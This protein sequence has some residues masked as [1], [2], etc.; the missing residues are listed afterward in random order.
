MFKMTKNFSK[1]YSSHSP[2][3]NAF[4]TMREKMHNASQSYFCGVGKPV[5]SER[6]YE[7]FATEAYRKNVI[8]H[9][10]IHM[11][12]QAASNVSVKLFKV[13]NSERYLLQNHPILDILQ[14]PNPLNSGKEFMETVYIYRLL[15][16]NVYIIG[17]GLDELAENTTDSDIPHNEYKD[18]VHYTDKYSQPCIKQNVKTCID[19]KQDAMDGERTPM[20][21]GNTSTVAL[22]TLRPDRV[23]VI[24]GDC[25]MPL[26]YRYTLDGGY[27]DYLIDQVSKKS[28]ILH[29]KNFNP[30]SDWYGLSSIEAAAYSIDQ[31]NQASAWNQALLQNGARPSGAIIVKNS[32]G[33]PTT[34][35]ESERENLRS[36]IDECFS[37]TVNAGR[38]FLLEGGLEWVDMSLSPKDMDYIESK[39]S[40]A[41]EIAL[42]L[43][44]PPQLLGIRGDNTYSNLSEAR[45]AFWEQTVIPLVS[46]TINSINRW[47]SQYFGDKL[48]LTCDLD[49]ISALAERIDSIWGRV[50]SSDFMTINEKRQAVG[51]SPIDDPRYDKICE[52]K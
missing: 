20:H 35:S 5:W 48:I 45:L 4:I 12:A 44:V 34:L 52:N 29:I 6:H 27:T 41:R 14:K 11:I 3:D 51:L 43:G 25:F 1:Q 19:N 9:R 13:V 31:H 32:D 30:L 50:Q 46:N 24:A 26:G 36:A 10:A 40:A 42:A 21:N 39:N 8:A 49:N 28:C 15:S 18:K 22:Y 37:G 16:G 7:E 2:Q 47:L 38:P 33:K 17:I 23:Q